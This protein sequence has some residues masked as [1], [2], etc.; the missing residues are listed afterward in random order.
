VANAP[1]TLD[2]DLIA[3]G[4]QHIQSEHLTVPHPRMIERAFVILPVIDLAPN[5]RHPVSGTSVTELRDVLPPDQAI[6]PMPPAQGV[7]HTE[8]IATP[9]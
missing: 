3:Y 9:L 2:L 6:E 7:C 1:R 4:D 5:W 8:W